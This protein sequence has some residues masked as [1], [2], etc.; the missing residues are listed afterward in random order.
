MPLAKH[1]SPGGKTVN[2]VALHLFFLALS[3]YTHPPEQISPFPSPVLPTHISLPTHKPQY[4]QAVTPPWDFPQALN[5]HRHAERSVRRSVQDRVP[6]C[7]HVPPPCSRT[8]MG[9]EPPAI[10]GNPVSQRAPLIPLASGLPLISTLKLLCPFPLSLSV[11]PT[12]GL[13]GAF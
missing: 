4:F 12:A 13:Y 9:T 7:E 3:D 1:G 2:S 11:C 10:P 6:V 5:A 8:Q